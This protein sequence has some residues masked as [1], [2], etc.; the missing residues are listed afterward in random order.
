MGIGPLYIL[1]LRGYQKLVTLILAEGGIDVN[2]QGGYVGNALQAA[3]DSGR[4]EIVRGRITTV[5]EQ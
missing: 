4:A 3:S 5:C 2:A 1:S